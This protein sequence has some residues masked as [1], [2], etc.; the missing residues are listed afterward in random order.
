MCGLIFT[1]SKGKTTV[2]LSLD[3]FRQRASD[4]TGPTQKTQDTKIKTRPWTQATL[5]TGL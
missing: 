2:L 1:S 5:T 4:A 3:F